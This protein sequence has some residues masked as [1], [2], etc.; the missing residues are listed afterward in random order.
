MA[1]NV[2]TAAAVATGAIDADAIADS[3]IDAGAIADGSLT[4]AKFADNFITA[5]K[6]ATDAITADKIAADAIGSSELAAGA[7]TEIATAVTAA[8]GTGSGLTTLA[9]AAELAKVPKSDGT[10]T[11]NAT[12]LA[13]INAEVDT[14]L[15]TA[16]PGSPTANSI[17]ER[18]AAIDDLTQAGGSGDLAAIL[19]DTG[20]TLQA[21]V[22]GIQADT[23]DIQ[24]RLVSLALTTGSVATD[25][26]NSATSFKT[27]L[28]SSTNDFWKDALLLITSG[29]LAG[30]VKK[31]TA[32]NGTTK[33]ITVEGGFTATPADAVTFT[34]IN[35]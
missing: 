26:S 31:I 4:A 23:E 16:I 22:D 19:T 2:V 27:D 15:N 12:A 13:S 28:S 9:T 25:G 6:I 32:Y 34:V 3:A 18:I 1:N 33:F 24:S 14:A 8:L 5:A 21:E 35:R 11:W 20:T 30:Q 17:N 29:A 7:A 10:A